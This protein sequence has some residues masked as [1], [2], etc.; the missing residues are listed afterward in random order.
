MGCH[1]MRHI[2]VQLRL[3]KVLLIH[4]YYLWLTSELADIHVVITDTSFL[5]DPQGIV[6]CLLVFTAVRIGK[7]RN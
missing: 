1:S 4:S 5:S 6:T 2:C 7:C 3:H